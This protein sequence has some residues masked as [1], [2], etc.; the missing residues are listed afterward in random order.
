M[1]LIRKS[2]HIEQ[3]LMR[4]KNRRRMPLGRGGLVIGDIAEDIASST[5]KIEG[6]GKA[7]LPEKE[8]LIPVS[9]IL[10]RGPPPLTGKDI[11]QIKNETIKLGTET[12]AFKGIA[13]AFFNCRS[14]EKR[15][16]SF[17]PQIREL[18]QVPETVE[19]T[20]SKPGDI[21]A[22]KDKGLKAIVKEAL[23]YRIKYVMTATFLGKTNE[24]AANELVAVIN[25]A[26]LSPLFKEG[27]K[28]VGRI[29]YK[30]DDGTYYCPSLPIISY[31]E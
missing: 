10:K 18:Q 2:V 20:L 16:N 12:F 9:K 31:L 11:E 4:N 6:M 8:M 7:K 24:D 13:Y 25:Q 26:Y 15:I 19:L 5:R 23:Q 1:T 17:L 28:F 22:R 27:E 29:Y 14:G 30:K 21:T 3:E